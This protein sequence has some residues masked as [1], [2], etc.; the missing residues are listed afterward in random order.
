[1]RLIP[2]LFV[3]CATVR[4]LLSQLLSVVPST[5]QGYRSDLEQYGY[6]IDKAKSLLEEAGYGDGLIG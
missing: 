2:S 4:I 1:M 5:L 3:R 6:D